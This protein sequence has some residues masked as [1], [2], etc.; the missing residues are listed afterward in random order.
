MT[1]FVEPSVVPHRSTIG[2][3]HGVTNVVEVS[4]EPVGRVVFQG[5]GAG[6]DATASAVLGDLLALAR[7]E[8]STWAA[9]PEAPPVGDLD[10]GA[11]RGQALARLPA[12]GGLTRCA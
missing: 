12:A 5:P 3:T 8:G 11:D 10:D 1:A 9:L 6:G 2:S 7:G 4:G